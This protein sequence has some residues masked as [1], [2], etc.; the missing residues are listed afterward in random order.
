MADDSIPPRVINNLNEF[1]DKI[2]NMEEVLR[3]VLA[4]TLEKCH[5]NVG[6]IY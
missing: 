4:T 6:C 3:P 2:T 1:H 5:E